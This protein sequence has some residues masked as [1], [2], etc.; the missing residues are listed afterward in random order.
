[1]STSICQSV[2]QSGCLSTSLSVSL[3]LCL[4]AS[5]LLY[6]SVCQSIS[7]SVLSMPHYLSVCESLYVHLS[8]HSLCTASQPSLPLYMS[9]SPH[10]LCTCLSVLTTSVPAFISLAPSLP[11]GPNYLSASQSV[12]LLSLPVSCGHPKASLRYRPA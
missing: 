11:L 8:P 2:C 10:Y 1:M 5:L 12:S 9:V 7:V 4:G 6:L 3:S